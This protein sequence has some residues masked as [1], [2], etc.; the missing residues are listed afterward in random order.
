MRNNM[1]KNK[2]ILIG[3]DHY[4]GLALVRLFGKHGFRP[5][6]IIVSPLAEKSF[7]ETSRY[8]E[9]TWRVGNDAQ[10]LPIMREHFVNEKSKP[11]I[12][13][14]S[15]GA[16]ATIDQCLDELKQDFILPSI[17][18]SQSLLYKMMDKGEQVLF[19]KECGLEMPR[20]HEVVLGEDLSLDGI[21][22]P[23]IG[24]PIISCEGNK[25]DIQ[26]KDNEDELK[27]YL[28][29]LQ[30]KG[31]SRILL[32]EYV[33]IDKEYDVEGFI[34]KNQSTYFVSEKVRTWPNI[35]GP[36]SYAFSVNE[37]KL[38]AE[39]D[40]VVSHLREIGYSGLFDVEIFRVGERFLFNEIN[41]R[42]SAV[43]FAAVASRIYYPLY[44]YYS[45]TGQN[46]TIH[47]PNMYGAFAMN[48]LLDFNHVRAKEIS[49]FEWLKQLNRSRA[50]AY[51]NIKDLMPLYKRILMSLIKKCYK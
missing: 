11:V 28:A 14:Y 15:D 3:G 31:Y 49:V 34:Y 13:P 37:P 50:K 36:T 24:K 19:A 23:C 4:N 6:G 26:K 17:N 45:V 10:I 20:S 44:W 47:K 9:K 25:K 32:Q 18:N 5:Y 21:V 39:I 43:C 46:Y 1:G 33:Q 27:Q 22:Y 40:K 7:L 51:Y 41:W 16:A 35:G 8:W 48:E 30:E 29:N 12:I 42:N 2:V 38:N